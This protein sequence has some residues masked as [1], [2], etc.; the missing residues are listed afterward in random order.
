MNVA[1]TEATYRVISD[2][3]LEVLDGG[4]LI[5]FEDARVGC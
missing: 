4:E 1:E 2:Q 5:G 3:E